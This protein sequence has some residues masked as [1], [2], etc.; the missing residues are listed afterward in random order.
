MRVPWR[1]CVRIAE[2]AKNSPWKDSAEVTEQGC[3]TIG[4]GKEDTVKSDSRK[5]KRIGYPSWVAVHSEFFT[6]MLAK[7]AN[8]RTAAIYL[9]LLERAH[10]H[11][12][13]CIKATIAELARRTGLHKSTVSASIRKLEGL[14][15][16]TCVY[17]GVQRS[18]SNKPVWQVHHARFVLRDAKWV[19][20]P[21][22][23]FREYLKAY[24]Q[25]V[26]VAL[27]LNYQHLHWR[28]FSWVG[29]PTLSERTG[30]SHAS[31]YKAIHVMGHK[32]KW[33]QLQTGLPFPLQIE[34]SSNGA[35]GHRRFAV[36]FASYDPK[37]KRVFLSDEFAQ[38]FPGKATSRGS[39]SVHNP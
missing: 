33:E 6:T 29:V 28:K 39:A 22:F 37:R 25:S 27:L 3:D 1:K 21:L 23:F 4:R 7:M 19:P 17:P 13:G 35:D 11:Q 14:H 5:D 8:P 9:T 38:R 32:Y 34:W 10:W 12:N 16:L 20:V 18:R 24:P 36:R 26:L 31:V 2:G 30:W 15:Y